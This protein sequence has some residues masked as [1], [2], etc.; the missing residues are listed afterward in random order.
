MLDLESRNYDISIIEE[1]ERLKRC[2]NEC[3]G[4]EIWGVGIIIISLLVCYLGS[5]NP[6]NLS[7]IWGYPAWYVIATVIM[8]IGALGGI[9]FAVKI[10]KHPNLTALDTGEEDRSDE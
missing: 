8:I 9:I 2:R 10:M 3:I 5:V 6:E 1:D 7:Y 4:V